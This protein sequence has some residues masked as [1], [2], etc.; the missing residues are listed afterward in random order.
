M[1]LVS[2]VE[3]TTFIGKL[4]IVVVAS[5]VTQVK[6]NRARGT[7]RDEIGA[8]GNLRLS[9]TCLKLLVL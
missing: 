9:D 8:T 3:D 4:A 6:K 7:K 2:C 5:T 1:S